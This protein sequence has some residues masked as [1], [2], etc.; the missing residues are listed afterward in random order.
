MNKVE[1][2]EL[3]QTAIFTYFVVLKPPEGCL[4]HS[5]VS[6]SPHVFLLLQ[7]PLS[8]LIPPFVLQ[9]VI[10]IQEERGVAS[11]TLSKGMTAEVL[12]DTSVFSLRSRYGSF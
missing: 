10:T 1:S 9:M 12:K 4:Y 8:S 6:F 7:L 3:R 5:I 11:R 2:G